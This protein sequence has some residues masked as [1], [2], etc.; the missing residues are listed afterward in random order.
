MNMERNISGLITADSL[1]QPES[2]EDAIRN[3]L[4][5][6]SRGFSNQMHLAV[7]VAQ[8][9]HLLAAK[10]LADRHKYEL[11]FINRVILRRAIESR[12]LLVVPC[13]G[14]SSVVEAE[15]ELAGMIHFYVRRDH[16]VTLCNIVVAQAYRRTGLGRQ[17]FEELVKLSQSMGKTQIRLKCPADLPA[18]HFYEQLGLDLVAAETGK[19]RPLNVWVYTIEAISR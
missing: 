19:R 12:S 2:I 6:N 3:E 18:N 17:L 9:G 10:K 15:T 16:T 11:G 8:I 14:V 13:P 1:P 7:V 4:V 5:A